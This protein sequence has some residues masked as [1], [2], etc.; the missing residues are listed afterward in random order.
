MRRVFVVVPLLW[1]CEQPPSADSLPEWNSA[2][3]HRSN[4]DDKIAPG[5]LQ[6]DP[7]SGRAGSA[8]D[9]QDP[10]QLADL[11]WR[12]QCTGCHG[13]TGKGDGQIGA[14]VQAPDLTKSKATDAEMVAA[15]KNGKSRM[16]KFSLPDPIVHQLVAR[17]REL[18]AR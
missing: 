2:R 14:M 1:A 10:S 12:Q 5:T 7:A 15:I 4:D 11:A 8:P 9:H 13:A 3:D 18:Q 6:G 16:P 17:I